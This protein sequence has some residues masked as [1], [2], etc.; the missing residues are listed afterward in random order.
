MMQI[1]VFNKRWIKRSA[2]TLALASLLSISGQAQFLKTKGQDIVETGHENERFI[3]RGVGLGGYMLQEGYMFQLSGLGTQSKIKDKIEQ[4]VG[5]EATDQF[6]KDWRKNFIQKADVDSMAAWGF[7]AIRLPFHYNLFTLP[8]EKEP[9]PGKQTFLP[10]GF[11]MV[12]SLL[13]WCKQAGIYLILDLHAAPG[14]QGNDLPI[15]DRDPALPSLW[16]SKANQDKTVALWEALAK[17][18]HNEP[19][20]GGYDLLNETNWG[21]ENPKD[22]RGTNEKN[23]APLWALLKRISKAIRKYDKQHMLI[24][25]GNGFANNYNGMGSAWDD[26]LVVSF[27]K[28]GNFNDEKSIAHFLKLRESLQVPV[29]LGE[30]GENYNN[31]YMHCIRLMEEHHIGWSWWPWKKMGGNNP[32]E[33]KRPSHYQDFLRFASGSAEKPS[34]QLGQQILSELISN[35]R[36]QNNI[37]HRDV[38]DAMFRRVKDPSAIPYK[39]HMLREGTTLDILAADYDLGANGYAYLD[40]DTARYQFTPGVNT[41]GNRGHA[42]RND[43]VDI[44]MDRASNMPYISFIKDG[45]WLSYTLSVENNTQPRYLMLNYSWEKASTQ[46]GPAEVDILLGDKLVGSLRLEKSHADHNQ[47]FSWSTQLEIPFDSNTAQQQLKVVFKQHCEG[48]LLQS[49]RIH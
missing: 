15:S 36:I 23:N 1:S 47:G 46:N 9:I 18:Y 30:S 26:N 43:G 13:S 35:L 44:M 34:L 45:E 48:L 4:M 28:Y 3:I 40:T 14:G 11:Q 37:I 33:I 27:H 19:Y 25:E 22:I 17:R 2:G 7:N 6:Y 42:Y 39:A 29:W 20:I 31:W 41:D 8:V 12:D 32:L 16:E 21:F 10:E 24:L 5:A 49:L 38:I